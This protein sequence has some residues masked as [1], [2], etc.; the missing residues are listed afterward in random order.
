MERA[1]GREVVERTA[2][3][4]AAGVSAV[5]L[6]D[7]ARCLPSFELTGF[8]LFSPQSVTSNYRAAIFVTNPIL[9]FLL[10]AMAMPSVWGHA[11]ESPGPAQPREA[12]AAESPSLLAQVMVFP[13]AARLLRSPA[14]GRTVDVDSCLSH[15]NISPDGTD[16]GLDTDPAPLLHQ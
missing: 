3:G 11:Y 6:P 8:P 14:I 12:A 13:A 1:P 10:L 16:S 7:D 5:A 4:L 15:P 9:L 2:F